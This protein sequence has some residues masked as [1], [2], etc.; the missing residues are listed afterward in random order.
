MAW[1]IVRH[2]FVI[3]FG[4]LGN[5]IKA[6][7]VPFLI[8]IG[9]LFVLAVLL[10]APLYQDA[11]APIPDD[12]AAGL[13]IVGLISIPLYLFVFAWIAVTWHRFILLEEYPATVPAV[14]GRPIGAYIARTLMMMLQ[15]IGVM[16]PLMLI[17]V[18]LLG[19]L[20]NP[21]AMTLTT[22]SGLIFAL[23]VGIVLSFFWLR[24]GVSL[25]GVA[26]D[27]PMNSRQAW[28]E[29]KPV[30]QTILGASVIMVVLNLLVSVAFSLLFTGI[31]LISYILSIII[32]WVTMMIG[33]SVLTTIYG[34]VVE[35]RSLSGT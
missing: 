21:D 26:V 7:L 30:W 35:G 10:G 5:A 18:P 12:Q 33:V 14:S 8:L 2:A 4:N 1:N 24:I 11:L 29:T 13:A 23:V 16:I 17:L 19:G 34:H 27:K 15:M 25:P 32:Q 28:S 9:V 3:V 6:S 20:A 31:P 22:T